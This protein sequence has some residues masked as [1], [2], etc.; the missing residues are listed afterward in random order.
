LPHNSAKSFGS[1]SSKQTTNKAD[2]TTARLEA[3]F[4]FDWIKVFRSPDQIF[5]DS[6]VRMPKAFGATWC[7]GV[8]SASLTIASRVVKISLSLRIGR[9][10]ESRQSNQSMDELGGQTAIRQP[11]KLSTAD[12]DDMFALTVHFHAASSLDVRA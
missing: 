12:H 1:A 5:L 10:F 2:S 11:T 4:L 9:F 6:V 8:L 7:T 3:L